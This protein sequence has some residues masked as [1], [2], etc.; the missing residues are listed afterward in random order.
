M[1]LGEIIREF[2]KEHHLSQRQFALLSGLSNGYISILEN[3]LNPKTKKPISPSLGQVNKLATGM[4]I[5]LQ[6]LFMKADDMPIDICDNA[7]SS[8]KEKTLLLTYYD[9]LN[10][11]GQE[12]LLELADDMVRSGKYIKNDSARVV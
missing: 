8:D 12:R 7:E 11:E 1:K 4:G 6:E 10:T 2:R 9:K 3:G 5:S